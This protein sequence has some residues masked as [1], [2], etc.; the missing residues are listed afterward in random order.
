MKMRNW[1]QLVHSSIQPFLYYC[2]NVS[3]YTDLNMKKTWS[4]LERNPC[5]EISFCVIEARF[6][7][8]IIGAPNYFCCKLHDLVDDKSPR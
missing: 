5:F 8:T 2:R 3:Y 6:D 4:Y 7:S 1:S